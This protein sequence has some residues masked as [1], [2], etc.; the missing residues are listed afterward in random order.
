MKTALAHILANYEVFTCAESPKHLQLDPKAM[1]LAI[2]GG[3][4]L[5]FIK[6]KH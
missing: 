2:R 5:K 6:L 1:I 3:I 4:H